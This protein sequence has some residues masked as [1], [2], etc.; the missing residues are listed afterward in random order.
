V[1]NRRLYAKFPPTM[2]SDTS[3]GIL[4]FVLGVLVIV[5]AV[6]AV[7]VAF[8][9]RAFRAMEQKALMSKLNLERVQAVFNDTRAYYQ[10]Y[11]TPE[12]AKI[13]Q[14]VQTKTPNPGA[15][16]TPTR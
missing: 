12:L 15:T 9:T 2:K 14:S 6:L 1:D 8:Q 7:N 10:K 5:G 4:T 16:P 3:N 11:P 13:L